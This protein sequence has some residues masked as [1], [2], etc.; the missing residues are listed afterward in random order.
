MSDTTLNQLQGE[1]KTEIAEAQ[2]MSNKQRVKIYVYLE[3]NG[4]LTCYYK[5]Q[6]PPLQLV[7]I[8]EPKELNKSKSLTLL[9][10]SVRGLKITRNN[11]SR[12]EVIG[13][14]TAALWREQ[15]KITGTWIKKP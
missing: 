9:C 8:A 1:F 13:A 3:T 12:A 11:M 6:N 5:I 15:E 14:L 2:K 4:H 10:D 7:Y